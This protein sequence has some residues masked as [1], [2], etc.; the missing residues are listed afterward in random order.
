MNDLS[1][2]LLCA[3]DP[4][5]NGA[6][7]ILDGNGKNPLM[8]VMPTIEVTLK[9]KTPAGNK[10]VSHELD[11]SVIRQI[12]IGIWTKGDET[13]GYDRDRVSHVFIEKQQPMTKPQ[14]KRCPKCGIPVETTQAQGIISTFNTGRNFGLLVGLVAGLKIPYTIVPAATWHAKM[15]KGV[16]GADS[17]AKAL[18]IAEQLFPGIDK[19]RSA[20]ARIAHDGICDAL[21]LGEFG[22]RVLSGSSDF[23]VEDE[24]LGF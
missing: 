24:A 14:I 10:R 17:K 22:R 15:L 20:K 23:Y 16:M 1:A 4:G 13:D 6:I 7:V 3:I 12:L 2:K 19:R 18:V 8:W 21:V 11:L 5:N 9:G